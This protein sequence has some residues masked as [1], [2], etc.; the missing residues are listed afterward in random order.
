MPDL[1]LSLSFSTTSVRCNGQARKGRMRRVIWPLVEM[2]PRDG[3]EEDE[4]IGPYI[5]NLILGISH[6]GICYYL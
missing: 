2:V 4:D 5:T 1:V 3:D 6:S